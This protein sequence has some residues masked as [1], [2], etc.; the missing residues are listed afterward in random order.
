M[1]DGTVIGLEN[2]AAISGFQFE[3]RTKGGYIT[4]TG[5]ILR[6][7]EVKTGALDTMGAEVTLSGIFCRAKVPLS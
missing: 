5:G 2:I 1:E 7:F 3:I 4:A 6:N